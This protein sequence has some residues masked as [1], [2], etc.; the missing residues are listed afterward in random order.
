MYSRARP[1]T[2]L[3]PADDYN[4]CLLP[5]SFQICYFGPW[6]NSNQH[7]ENDSVRNVSD[8]NLYT[9]QSPVNNSSAKWLIVIK[10][11]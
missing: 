3:S 9:T 5:R 10:I 1:G 11:K 7:C 2:G 4:N 6:L 8:T